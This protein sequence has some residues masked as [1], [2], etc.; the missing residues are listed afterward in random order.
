MV[1]TMTETDH[2]GSY[3]IVNTRQNPTNPYVESSCVAYYGIT[4]KLAFYYTQ[5]WNY[6]RGVSD[7]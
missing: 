7:I 5:G 3:K 1:F 2:N 6:P 4:L